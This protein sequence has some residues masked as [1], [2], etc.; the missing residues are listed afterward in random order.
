MHLLTS[1]D[2]FFPI[3]CVNRTFIVSCLSC[4]TVATHFSFA[5]SSFVTISEA[6]VLVR[7]Q[8][9]QEREAPVLVR[10]Q[11]LQERSEPVVCPF[12]PQTVSTLHAKAAYIACMWI[13]FSSI[14]KAILFIPKDKCTLY[15]AKQS[16]YWVTSLIERRRRYQYENRR[17]CLT[18]R[19]DMSSSW[20]QKCQS[21]PPSSLVPDNL[22]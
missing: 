1:Q 2:G 7:S 20:L 14:S 21:G 12:W 17:D 11:S 4:F 8:S 18:V 6:P 16:P 22:P 15:S 9:L 13:Y 10:S 5:I 3:Q 19:G